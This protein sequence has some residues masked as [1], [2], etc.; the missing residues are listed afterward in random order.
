[1][2]EEKEAIEHELRASVNRLE[3][4]TVIKQSIAELLHLPSVRAINTVDLDGFQ[5]TRA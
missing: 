5:V 2:L 4:D 3:T 1:M